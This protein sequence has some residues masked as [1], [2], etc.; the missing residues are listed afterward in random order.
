MIRIGSTKVI[1]GHN[2]YLNHNSSEIVVNGTIVGEIEYSVFDCNTAEIENSCHRFIASPGTYLQQYSDIA[3][4]SNKLLTDIPTILRNDLN[5]RNGR[6]LMVD[7]LRIFN[8]HVDDFVEIDLVKLIYRLR[9]FDCDILIIKEWSNTVKRANLDPIKQ[10]SVL[11]DN[12]IIPMN[13][14]TL[15][16][17][18]EDIDH[19]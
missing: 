4:D 18:F 3:Y 10:L 11:C 6:F 5:G 14:T 19:L 9:K 16:G 1:A 15:I 17:F 12:R 13:E 8:T 2:Q 7:D